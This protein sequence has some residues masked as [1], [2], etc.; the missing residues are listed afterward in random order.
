MSQTVCHRVVKIEKV[1]S[2]IGWGF[3]TKGDANQHDDRWLMTSR[4]KWIEPDRIRGKVWLRIP[5]LGL[6]VLYIKETMMGKVML[7]LLLR[8][9]LIELSSTG[10]PRYSQTFYLRSLFTL[11]KLV[12]ND[13]F[14]S[15]NWTFYP[16]IQDLR[17]KMTE[18]IYRV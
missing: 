16:R 17:F 11:T 9:A 14:S 10:G 6:P 1:G 8:S 7:K 3:M 15:Q 13:N 18:R 4:D 2:R 5:K 12:K